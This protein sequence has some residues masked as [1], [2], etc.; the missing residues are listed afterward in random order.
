MTPLP[1]GEL[2]RV[3]SFKLEGRRLDVFE[4]KS[5]IQELYLAFQ[6]QHTEKKE[7]HKLNEGVRWQWWDESEVR[8]VDYD[9]EVSAEIERAYKEGRPFVEPQNMG[10]FRIDVRAMKEIDLNG[11]LPARQTK[12][13]RLDL[14][15]G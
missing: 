10:R 8:Y 3:K 1:Y 15:G 2:R 7:A 13:H 12:I 5:D 9:P 4:A 14:V 11:G 6:K